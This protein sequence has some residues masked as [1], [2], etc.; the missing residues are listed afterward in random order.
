MIFTFAMS[1]CMLGKLETKKN[2]FDQS[3]HGTKKRPSSNKMKK[4]A[5]AATYGP[6]DELDTALVSA[7][8]GPVTAGGSDNPSEEAE[9]GEE[10]LP[11]EEDAEEEDGTGND[12]Q[13]DVAATPKAKSQAK[14]KAKAKQKAKAKP[15]AS[16]KAKATAKA[17]A[18]AKAKQGAKSKVIPKPKPKGKGKGKGQGNENQ[19]EEKKTKI[20]E[21]RQRIGRCQWMVSGLHW[22]CLALVSFVSWV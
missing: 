7:P 20:C 5:A 14:A 1:H 17:K 3:S 18:S 21:R 8:G 16:S 12:D 22:K 9:Q 13:K 4:P 19:Q 11:L 15:K 10:E 6:L 2:Q